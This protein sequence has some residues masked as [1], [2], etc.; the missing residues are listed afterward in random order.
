MR[1]FVM[2]DINNFPNLCKVLLWHLPKYIKF[3]YLT[4]N[5]WNSDELL[6]V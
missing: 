5:K 6:T 2:P 1:L 4:K 3:S